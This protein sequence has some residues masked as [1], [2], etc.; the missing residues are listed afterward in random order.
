M[1]ALGRASYRL[2]DDDNI[3]LGKIEGQMLFALE[4]GKRRLKVDSLTICIDSK[5]RRS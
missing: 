5:K 3:Y 2:R 4:E 1:I